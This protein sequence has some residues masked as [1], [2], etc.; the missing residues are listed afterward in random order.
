MTSI[1]K[2]DIQITLTEMKKFYDKLRTMYS[3]HG[4]NLEDNLGRRN[5]LMSMVQEEFQ[6]LFL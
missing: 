6:K 1:N 3:S 4:M 2:E 5:I